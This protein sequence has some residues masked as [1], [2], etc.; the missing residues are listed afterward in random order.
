MER[1]PHMTLYT[2]TFLPSTYEERSKT[3]SRARFKSGARPISRASL[4]SLICVVSPGVDREDG[5]H[6]SDT[7][8]G[9]CLCVAFGEALAFLLRIVH[10]NQVYDTA[11]RDL[12]FR[13]A[14]S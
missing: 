6:S 4:L 2:T 5:L 14:P 13:A 9:R 7:R 12:C 11:V 10:T 8:R 3:D 1:V